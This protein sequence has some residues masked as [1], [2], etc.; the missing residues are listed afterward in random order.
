MTTPTLSTRDQT[1][2]D[3]SNK[4]DNSV[5]QKS[6][7]DKRKREVFKISSKH[8]VSVLSN[9][10][11]NR[12]S[13]YPT[14]DVT[15]LATATEKMVQTLVD[16]QSKRLIRIQSLDTFTTY[17]SQYSSSRDNGN[18][19]K[20]SN[21]DDNESLDDKESS[22]DKDRNR[23][24]RDGKEDDA[25]K[26]KIVSGIKAKIIKN[27]DLDL[28]KLETF[29][30]IYRKFFLKQNQLEDLTLRRNP[31]LLEKKENNGNEEGLKIDPETYL[32]ELDK[33]GAEI[34]SSNKDGKS[35]NKDKEVNEH[36]DN[37]S[38]DTKND[39]K[40]SSKNKSKN[41]GRTE[42]DS[43]NGMKVLVSELKKLDWEGLD[44]KRKKV[45]K[46]WL[47]SFK[48]GIASKTFHD[49]L[50]KAEDKGLSYL[51]FGVNRKKNYAEKT[52][53]NKYELLAYITRM[54]SGN[55]ERT[56]DLVKKYLA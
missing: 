37:G 4:N 2:N 27:I 20:E 43:G 33:E 56:K 30:I 39:S 7:S 32:K 18:S 29:D 14:L 42:S 51:R 13:S 53:M 49:D 38:S 5:K 1:T 25:D 44:E 19:N 12:L 21:N 26:K 36:N 11:T 28:L 48:K 9:M 41:K 23:N 47:D 3:P 17:S 55:Q 35:D 10:I 50:A 34:E 8:T 45:G 40:A 52:E 16:M 6:S 31:A 46:V 15:A 54:L 24:N 22:D